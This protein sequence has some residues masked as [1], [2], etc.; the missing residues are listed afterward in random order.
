MSDLVRVLR[1][2]RIDGRG[3]DE[4]MRRA[5][6]EI[7]RLR[8]RLAEYEE[9]IQTL[10]DHNVRIIAD[11]EARLAG[12]QD[13]LSIALAANHD[14]RDERDS[15]KDRLADPC[16]TYDKDGRLLTVCHRL[17]EAEAL[18]REALPAVQSYARKHGRAVVAAARRNDA[19][20]VAKHAAVEQSAW[21]LADK[22]RAYLPPDSAS[23]D[24]AL[25]SGEEWWIDVA[26][27]PVKLDEWEPGAKKRKA[28][29][30]TGVACPECGSVDPVDKDGHSAGCSRQAEQ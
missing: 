14:L 25:E 4:I 29:Q 18:L 2:Q 26:G 28:S 21:G 3:A 12:V 10:R 5:A 19:D 27:V 6:D 1:G 8:S 7:E 22:I 24:T 11:Y 20:H 13:K 23:D 15:L 17:A 30:P 9:H 16:K